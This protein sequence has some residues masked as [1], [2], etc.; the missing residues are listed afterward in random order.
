MIPS[1]YLILPE[2][3]P[4]PCHFSIVIAALPSS[5]CE[6]NTDNRGPATYRH[7]N[8]QIVA[9]DYNLNIQR[10]VDTFETEA[11]ID[12]A[13]VQVQIDALEQELATTQQQLGQYFRD[14]RL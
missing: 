5:T 8:E 7:T 1:K 12:V 9:T 6:G 10:Y 11:E 4:T 3:I 13:V 14:L 2:W